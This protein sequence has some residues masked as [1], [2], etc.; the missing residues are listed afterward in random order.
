M[1]IA[2]LKR[3]LEAVLFASGEAVEA[4]RLAKLFSV[5]A[6]DIRRLVDVINDDFEDFPFEVRRLGDSYQL[7]TKA[8]YAD[9][10]RQALEA[11]RNAPLSPAALEVLAIVAYNQP[12]TRSFIEQ[13]RG[14]DSSSV[15]SSLVAKGL[16]E[17]RGRLEIPGRPLSYGTTAAFLRCF[18]LQDIEA[19]PKV[20]APDPQ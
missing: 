9:I 1:A 20:P 8:Q 3:Q 18:G 6:D 2:D 12:V 5:N 14:T 4:Q 11:K 13:I 10:I 15:L 17:E 16:V 7:L 19:L